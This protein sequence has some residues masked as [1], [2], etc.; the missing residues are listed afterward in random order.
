MIASGP[1]PG[2]N[3]P[4]YIFSLYVNEMQGSN[5]TPWFNFNLSNESNAIIPYTGYTQDELIVFWNTITQTIR[6]RPDAN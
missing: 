5:K 2:S 4:I 6:M 3:N 1:K